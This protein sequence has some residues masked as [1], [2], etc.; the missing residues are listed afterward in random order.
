MDRGTGIL[1]S[2]AAR[3]ILVAAVLAVCLL[4]VLPVMRNYIKQYNE[5][6]DLRAQIAQEQAKNKALSNEL[7]RWDD[8]SY[9]IAQARE[10]LTFV[11]PGETPYKVMGWEDEDVVVPQ[12]EKDPDLFPEQKVPWYQSMWMSIEKAGTLGEEADGSK[13]GSK[14]SSKDR[15]KDSSK[16]ED[17]TSGTSGKDSGEESTGGTTD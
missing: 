5:L 17:S 15:S 13:P 8:E 11:F 3:R 10:R 4:V 16:N 14:S 7:A 1:N 2:R 12:D 6:S 9:V